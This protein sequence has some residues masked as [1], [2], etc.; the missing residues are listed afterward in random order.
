MKISITRRGDIW[1]SVIA[2]K[3]LYSLACY[4]LMVIDLDLQQ[5]EQEQQQQQQQQLEEFETILTIEAKRTVVSQNSCFMDIFF[6][7]R[8]YQIIDNDIYYT[9]DS[10]IIDSE[11][12][13]SKIGET[14]STA[15]KADVETIKAIYADYKKKRDRLRNLLILLNPFVSFWSWWG[16]LLVLLSNAGCCLGYLLLMVTVCGT[17]YII[18]VLDYVLFVRLIF[19]YYIVL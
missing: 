19:W 18:I 5:Q 1:H 14:V 10:F 6:K 17:I 15:L 8:I 4:T 2:A 11:L 16:R 3:S 13:T 12:L 7:H 9:S